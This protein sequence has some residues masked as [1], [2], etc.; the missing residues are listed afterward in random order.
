[1][2][3]EISSALDGSPVVSMGL[4]RR[5]G[6]P[7]LNPIIKGIGAMGSDNI[8]TGR[9]IMG[10]IGV[11]S[12]TA[13]GTGR[14]SGGLDATVAAAMAVWVARVSSSESV[15]LISLEPRGISLRSRAALASAKFSN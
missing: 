11:M 1:M 13:V 9:G 2:V 7:S 3:R 6:L 12:G 4:G 8:G 5:G 14:G 15:T 10:R